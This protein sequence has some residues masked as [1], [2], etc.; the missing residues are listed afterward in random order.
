M[1]ENPGG[2]ITRVDLTL[3]SNLESVDKAEAS[4]LRAAEEM[5]FDEDSRY[6]I[7]IAVRESVVNAVV[8]GNCYSDHKKV[9]LSVMRGPDRLTVT[10]ADEGKGFDAESLP[11]PLAKE[12]LM[13]QSGRGIFLMRAFMD[14][15]DIRRL[16]P[17]GTEFRLV[18]YLGANQK[19]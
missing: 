2:E 1:M 7:G 5:G 10:V 12:N 13:N 18:K 16:E 17:H 11:D 15:F 8:H 14:E 19:P 4:V 9:R 3:D 6:Q